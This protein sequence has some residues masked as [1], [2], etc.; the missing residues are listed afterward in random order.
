MLFISVLVTIFMTILKAYVW[1]LKQM[2]KLIWNVYKLFVCLFPAAGIVLA[3]LVVFECAGFATGNDYIGK[4][5]DFVSQYVHA[6]AGTPLDNTANNVEEN[7]DASKT[8]I[9]EAENISDSTGSTN[10][11]AGNTGNPTGSTS[12]VAGTASD[13]SGYASSYASDLTENLTSDLQKNIENGVSDIS[14]KVTQTLLQSVT[15]WWEGILEQ[16]EQKAY[17]VIAWAITILIGIPIFLGLLFLSAAASGL[18]FLGIAII[19]DLV[20]YIAR[21]IF[22]MTTPFRQFRRRYC[23]LFHTKPFY[24]PKYEDS[25]QD[26]LKRHHDEFEND[27]FGTDRA[28]D[29]D[30]DPEEDYNRVGKRDFEGRRVTRKEAKKLERIKKRQ[31]NYDDYYEDYYDRLESQEEYED[32]EDYDS[33]YDEEDGYDRIDGFEAEDEECEYAGRSSRNGRNSSNNRN[34]RD[35]RADQNS[36]NNYSYS[37]KNSQNSRSRKKSFDDYYEDDDEENEDYS[38][39]EDEA[40]D[41]AFYEQSR[42]KTRTSGSSASSKDRYKTFDFFAGCR[43]RDGV[44]K[45]YHS[46]AKLYHP[47][48]LE[49]DSSAITEINRQY[50][51]AMGK[52]K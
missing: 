40:D 4:A 12:D 43:S 47:D 23:F 49:G 35:S 36:S 29:E 30:Y 18:H 44:V 17:A 13:I 14:E 46:L 6:Q 48:N 26:W 34:H 50:K 3:A 39:F 45:K 25:Y 22:G 38:Q 9:Y 20:L 10:N 52:Y 16:S 24:D 5:S 51:E 21:S 28:Y 41:D 37:R 31:R 33:D 19:C 27:T 32:D 11:M 8:V 42:R 2:F 7:G 15:S 1:L